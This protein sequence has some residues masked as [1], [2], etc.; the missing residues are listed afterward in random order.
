MKSNNKFF[1]LIMLGLSLFSC[2]KDE[3]RVDVPFSADKATVKVGENV[4][5]TIGAGADLSSIYTGDQGKDFEKSRINLVETK[6]YKEEFLRSNLLAERLP[7]LKEYFLYVP[8]SPTVPT[9]MSLSS[10]K[11]S[12][13]EGKLVPWDVSNVTNSKYLSFDVPDEPI[14][15]TIKPNNAV[16]PGMLKY[17]N[18]NLITLGALNSVVNNNL[19]MLMAFPDG[20]KKED[21]DGKAM[22]FSVQFVI[23]GKSST[24]AYFTTT[25]REL[26]IPYNVALQNGITALLA[27]NPTANPKAGID[28]IIFTINADNP[29]TIEDDGP[30]LNYVGKVYIQ[31]IRVGTSD[32]MIKVFDKGFGLNYIYPGTTQTYQYK[33]TK[34]GTYTATLVSTYVGRKK[35]S[36]DGYKTNRADEVLASEYPLERRYKKVSIVVE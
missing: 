21:Q 29:A 22:K 3:L 28:E 4:T 12:I 36:G 35:Y 16:L 5:F 19:S 23:D 24:I 31:D 25:V 9:N 11:L 33:Y 17:T 7:D 30:L 6:G 27:A 20:F 10:G 8:E 13:Y 32:N 2:E 26:L 34:P 14:S 18:T 1:A 15:W